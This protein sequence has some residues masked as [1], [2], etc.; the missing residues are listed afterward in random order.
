MFTPRHAGRMVA[1]IVA[2][3]VSFAAHGLALFDAL[4][5]SLS[6]SA[7]IAEASIAS[8]L[9]LDLSKE[10]V[11]VQWVGRSAPGS[12]DSCDLTATDLIPHSSYVQTH[13][14]CA[15]RGATDDPFASAPETELIAKAMIQQWVVL[16]ILL[17]SVRQGSIIEPSMVG[18]RWIERKFLSSNHVLMTEEIIGKQAKHGLMPLIP[19]TKTQLTEP[20]YVE[21]GDAVTL[22]FQRRG[23]KLQTEA[24][25]L[26]SGTRNQV[27]QLRNLRS[28]QVVRAKVTDWRTAEVA[29]AGPSPLQEEAR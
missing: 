5:T 14:R 2:F 16:P 18:S 24:L 23:L 17:Q 21:R 7:A 10:A 12:L 8:Q 26:E 3:A 4:P 15:A 13:W 1:A 20:R 19:L 9:G 25:A 6:R 27:I 28:Q 29:S 11:R 22:V